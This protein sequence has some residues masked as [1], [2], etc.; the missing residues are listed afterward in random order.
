[1]RIAYGFGRDRYFHFRLHGLSQCSLACRGGARPR[2]VV[3]PP[4]VAQWAKDEYEV[5]EGEDRIATLT[6][7]TAAGVPK[8]RAAYNVKVLTAEE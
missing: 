8:P 3:N 5:D 7:K 2:G 6:L 4:I 1:M